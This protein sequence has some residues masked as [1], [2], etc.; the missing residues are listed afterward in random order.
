MKFRNKSDSSKNIFRGVCYVIFIIA[1]TIPYA[2]LWYSRFNRIQALMYK[3]TG[4]W[5]VIAMYAI[6]TAVFL[7][8]FNGHQVGVHR[9]SKLIL[10][11]WIGMFF[12]DI[13]MF[14]IT[15]LT[16]GLIEWI[17]RVAYLFAALYALQAVM[18]LALSSLLVD[19]YR[20]LF[21]PL[22]VLEIYGSK[23]NDLSDKMNARPDKY[24]I[25]DFVSYEEDREQ[26]I[27]LID[28]HDAVLLNDVPSE[29]KNEWVKY[30]FSH[31]KRVYF[32][33]KI[34][35]IIIKAATELNLFDTTIYLSRN[36]GLTFT[37]RTV[38]RFF[39]VV[40]SLIAIIVLSPLLAI[41]ALCIHL[42][43]KGPVFY[44]QERVTIHGRRFMI[45]KFRSMIVNAEEL[46]KSNP[47]SSDDDRITK[48]GRFIRATRI[49]E[50]PQLFNILRGDMSIVG[51]RPERVEHVIKYKDEV[52]EFVLREKVRGG[53]TGY[54]QVYGKYNT[55]ALDKLKLDISYITNYSI[56]L[57]VQIILETLK[58]IFWRE[59]TE[60]FSDEQ[61]K[62]IQE[63]EI[64]EKDTH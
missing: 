20:K 25:H 51:P 53:L 61:K 33:P 55:T 8:I 4:N 11:Q 54:A 26:I 49:D 50:L 29:A 14:A 57:D 62:K 19:L 30:C 37:Q 32:P 6:V 45:I 59:S 52:P 47:A 58:V 44:K 1:L 27:K 13:I 63:K 24:S 41:V 18:L 9:K 42:E 35:D 7:H 17:Y 39:D 22:E 38:K 3:L 36:S 21:P 43:D 16:I 23:R 46:G 10:S 40:L 2:Y 5:L 64:Q 56:I 31:N 12:A 34:S 48:T 60:G 28:E 15:V